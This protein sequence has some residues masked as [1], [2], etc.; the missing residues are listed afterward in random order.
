MTEEELPR[1]RGLNAQPIKLEGQTAFMVQDP[2][3]LNP[4]PVI[5]QPAAY[6]VLAMLDGQSG[7]DDIRAACRQR[8]GVSLTAQAVLNIVERLDEFLLLDTERARRAKAAAAA[9][10]AAA[11]HRPASHA[12]LSY[13]GRAGELR[14][15]LDRILSLAEPSP[16]PDL[17]GLVAPH[18]DLARGAAVYASAYQ[19]LPRP[20][21]GRD[22][23]Y[24]LLGTAHTPT[25]AMFIPC[26]KDFVTPLGRARTEAGPAKRLAAAAGPAAENDVLVHLNEHSL[27]FQIIF[28]QHLIDPEVRILPILCGGLA[29]ASA[30]GDSPASQGIGDEFV[31]LL[32]EIVEREGALVVIGADL[33]HV[34]PQFGHAEPV[35]P[36]DQ[37]AVRRKDMEFLKLVAERNAEAAFELIADEL[38]SRNVCGLGPIY[39]ALRLLGPG[40][41]RLA[42]YEQWLDEGGSGLVSFAAAVFTK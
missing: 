35:S 16:E 15:E 7:L 31:V 36:A 12:G 1:A 2:L 32:S 23:L 41:G 37:E 10:F 5:L 27:E 29:Q 40:P 6:L 28:L 17:I 25:E 11:D 30:G 14:A 13:P 8:L 20:E 38:D 33:A 19:A 42:G 18:I 9:D 22:R 4:R 39:A 21:D 26:T 34:G 24:V 3:G